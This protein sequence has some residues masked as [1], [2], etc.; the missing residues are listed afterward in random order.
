MQ[1]DEDNN[2]TY[3]QKRILS[4]IV[5]GSLLILMIIGLVQSIILLKPNAIVTEME[6]GS[7]YNPEKKSY[8]KKGK[9]KE[10]KTGKIHSVIIYEK[11]SDDFPKEGDK[12][13]I[14]KDLGG[15]WCID[16]PV[17]NCIGSILGIA[18]SGFLFYLGITGNID[19]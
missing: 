12:V 13:S 7:N 1:T 6:I 19:E 5:G 18:I 9:V 17:R 3:E 15:K 11:N 16:N 8:I 4:I 10:L 14:S 2:I